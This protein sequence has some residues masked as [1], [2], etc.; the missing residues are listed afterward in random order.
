MSK[1]CILCHIVFATKQRQMV[2]V[3]ENKR[4]LYAY[5]LGIINDRGCK[6]LR[7]GGIENHVHL[8]IDLHPSVALAD[9][10]KVL[11][12]SSSNWLRTNN[13]FPWFRGWASGYFAGSV[14]IDGKQACI[15]YIMNQ[16]VHH[17]RVSF[18]DE[19][20]YEV[21]RWGLDFVDVEW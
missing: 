15:D 13:L 14:G 19:M 11:K 6:A 10:V 20:R 21:E 9:L 7:I 8:L 1:T 16:E 5:F 3:P 12:Q 17:G 2:I 18:I 4:R